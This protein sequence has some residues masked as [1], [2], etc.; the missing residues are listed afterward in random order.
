MRKTAIVL[1]LASTALAA[2][3]FARDKSWYVGVEGGGMIVEKIHYNVNA[4]RDRAQAKSHKGYDVGGVVG[5]DLGMFR[6]EA[7]TSYRH[8]NL[9]TW[10]AQVSTPNYY[11]NGVLGALPVGTYA[12][13]TGSTSALSFMVNGLADFGDDDGLQGF[14]GGGAG[15]ARTKAKYAISGRFLND[16]DTRFAYQ[17]LAGVRYPLTSH[18]DASVSYRFFSTLNNRFIDITNRQLSGRFRSHSILAGLTYNFGEPA[19][20]PP[21]PPPPRSVTRTRPT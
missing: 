15:V 12:N 14:V 18:V 10:Q 4:V 20:P 3:A 17:G 2:P 8:A 7:E 5:Y 19:A 1:A 13:A 16:S 6:V 11:T 9:D 21:P